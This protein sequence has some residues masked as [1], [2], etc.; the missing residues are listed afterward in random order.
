M[1]TSRVALVVG[2]LSLALF[3]WGC[4]PFQA[5]QDKVNEKIGEKV[6]EGILG[7]A[8]G[9][10][11][12]LNN[13]GEDVTF[14]DNKNGGTASFGEDVKLPDGFPS[15]AI[16]Y[17]GAKNKGVTMNTKD[18]VAVW[19]MQETA[20]DV[21]KVADW[22]ASETKSKGWTED[23]NM[24]LGGSALVSWSKDGEK[25]GLSATPGENEEAGKTTLIVT[26]TEEK[27][28]DA[29]SDDSGSDASDTTAG[30]EATE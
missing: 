22:Y 29:T 6:A 10:D 8:T 19:V 16:L 24:N 3:G 30:E 5:A 28:A 14:T 17:P 4:N 15:S 2:G 12:D 26:W 21:K 25:L 1:K 9:A 27:K 18:N 11:I 23:S 7:K 20:D 13:G